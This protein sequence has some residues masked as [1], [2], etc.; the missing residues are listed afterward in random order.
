MEENKVIIQKQI[1]PVIPLRGAVIF[2]Y[3]LM[4]F[5][6]A[7]KKSVAAL[8][9]AMVHNQLIFFVTQKSEETE[10][11]KREDL[12]STGT[13]ARIKQMLK[14]PGDGIRVLAEGVSRAKLTG[15]F[16][17][18]KYISC[19][20]TQENMEFQKPE[21]LE[22][23]AMKRKLLEVFEEY[24][25]ASGKS[26]ED[27]LNIVRY[28]DDV[29]RM[30]DVIAAGMFLKVEEK[31]TLL[32]E[33][34]PYR[35]MIQLIS[36]LMREETILQV[37]NKISRMVQSQMEHHQHEYFLREQMKAIQ[38]ELGDTGEKEAEQYREKI[39]GFGLPEEANEKLEKDLE[40]LEQMPSSS[41]EASV[42]RSYLDLVCDLPW[43]VVTKETVS[44]NRAAKILEKD[45]YGLQDVKERVLEFLAVRKLT[46][47]LQGSVLCLVG[48]PGVGK[49]SVAKSIAKALGRNY[50]R[51]SLGGIRDEADI[52]GHRKTYIGSMPGRLIEAIRRA[53]SNNPLILLDEIDKMSCDFHGDPAS[54]MLEVLDAE[55]NKAFCDHYLEIPYDLS[56]VMFVTTANQLDTIP[57]PLLDRLEVISISGYTDYEK[58]NIAERY[59]I[60]KQRHINGL[61]GRQLSIDGQAITDILDFYTREAG[62]R[63]LEREIGTICRKTARMI[64]SGQTKTVRVLSENLEQFLGKRKYRV[65]VMNERDEIGIATGLAWT[66]VGGVT[67]S[68]EVNVMDG[69]GKT[70]LTGQLGD[71]M[72]ESARAAI[73]FLR[74]KAE[75]FGIESDFYKKKDLHIHVPEGATPKDGPSAGITIATAILSALT[76]IPVRRNVAMTGEITLR[77]RVLPIGGLKEKS[78]AAYRAGI[79]TVLIPSENQK[80][81]EDIPDEICESMEFIPVCQMEQVIEAALTKRSD[82]TLPP[83]NGTIEIL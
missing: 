5:D 64:A 3:M 83:K 8:E 23:E 17:G 16:E 66:S 35:R 33:F 76:E 6:I 71:V 21:P 19:E 22:E 56:Q 11:P 15:F 50:V 59:L 43:N 60:P 34:D 4:H 29:Q 38:S 82:I 46:G 78:L 44:L 80:D 2:P 27:T 70:E 63:H 1:L 25:R 28:T 13:V 47:N 36:L 39:A 62:V 69:T 61:T 9:E 68:V 73:S 45:H 57:A 74:S 79:R 24:R 65:D 12:Y 32:Q 75:H 49:T 81:L 30:T 7:R 53:K 72:Q 41:Q 14:L 42:L 51:L 40:R 67:L 31:Q 54:A 52:R 26:S 55:Q 20:I 48:P 58:R 37:E 77:G 18:E 10:Q